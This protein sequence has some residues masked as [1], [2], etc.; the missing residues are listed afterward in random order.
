MENT[1]KA[2]EKWVKSHP[3]LKDIAA[4][5]TAFEKMLENFNIN[6]DVPDIQQV[7]EQFIQGIPLLLTDLDFGIDNKAGWCS[8]L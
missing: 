4:L 8:I 2:V 6:A 7:K 5:H 1:L 3:Y